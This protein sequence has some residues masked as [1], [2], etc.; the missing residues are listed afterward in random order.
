MGADPKISDLDIT[1]IA[2]ARNLEHWTCFDC[3]KVFKRPAR[4]ENI[5]S[6]PLTPAKPYVCPQCRRLMHDMGVHFE[7]PRR[8]DTKGWA[9][10]ELLADFGYGY[11]TEGDKS[12][13]D[14]L[15]L[16]EPPASVRELRRRL[17]Q[18]RE[19]QARRTLRRNARY[20]KEVRRQN[21]L[22]RRLP[23]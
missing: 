2:R 7:P 23:G 11:Y 20:A 14:R 12:W 10:A 9:R 21:A 3:R 22:V 17:V 19:Q 18:E 15:L 5:A 1:R 13:I 6:G 8:A 4:P 16:G